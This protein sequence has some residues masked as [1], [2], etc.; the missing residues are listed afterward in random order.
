MYLKNTAG[1]NLP[2]AMIKSSD[3][4]A[5]TGATVTGRCSIDGGAQTTVTGM[6][7][8]KGYGEYNL[9]LSQADTNGNQIGYLFT[10][11]GAIPVHITVA[12]GVDEAGIGNALI[13]HNTG[14]T[15]A[16]RYVT[17]SGAGIADASIIAYLKTEYDSGTF[18]VRS[19][20]RTDVN[21][22]WQWP[23]MVQSGQTYKL[24]FFKTGEYLT[25]VIEVTA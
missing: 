20:S 11:T 10:A 9:A 1:Q 17:S 21:G 15:D 2:F 12:M 22:R 13:N 18:T 25:S 16:L 14:G 19:Q 5:L 6:I 3:G 4:T 7:T 8:E 23:M 24:I